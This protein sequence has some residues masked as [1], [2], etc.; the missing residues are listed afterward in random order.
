MLRHRLVW[1]IT[2]MVAT[3]LGIDAAAQSKPEGQLGAALPSAPP[4]LPPISIR[5]R[6]PGSPHPCF[7]MPFMTRWSNPSWQS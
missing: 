6:P 1:V 5:P 4:L 3:L 7:S 2:W